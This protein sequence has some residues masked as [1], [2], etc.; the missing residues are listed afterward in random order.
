M[1]DPYKKESGSITYKRIDQDSMMKDVQF[2]E[3][4]CVEYTEDFDARGGARDA[5]MTLSLTI[6]AN[7]ITVGGATLDN[8]WVS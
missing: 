2:E 7:K 6:S 3:A 8:K 5:S 4:Y 1:L